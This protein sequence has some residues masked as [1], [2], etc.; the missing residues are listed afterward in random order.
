MLKGIDFQYDEDAFKGQVQFI[1]TLNDT[2]EEEALELA[3]S[4]EDALLDIFGDA[5]PRGD[6]E[7][8]WSANPTK[9]RNAQ[10]YWYAAVNAGRILTDGKHYIRQQKPPRGGFVKVEKTDEGFVLIVGNEW[11][12]SSLLYGNLSPTNF[13]TQLIGHAQTG[14]Q[15]A[16]PKYEAARNIFVRELF[17]RVLTRRFGRN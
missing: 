6:N 14:Y 17:D 8:I 2:L 13:D 5:P 15:L 10:R 12:K 16:Q 3:I 4:L 11:D 9:N 7:F 1:Q